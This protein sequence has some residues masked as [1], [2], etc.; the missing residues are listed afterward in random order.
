MVKLFK[1]KQLKQV[2]WKGLEVEAYLHTGGREGAETAIY[3]NVMCIPKK[4][5]KYYV[6]YIA[7]GIADCDRNK[8]VLLID[9]YKKRSNAIAMAKI[10]I[11]D[12]KKCLQEVA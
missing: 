8:K 11:K 6:S 1:L 3:P 2:L 7:Y 9:V 12:N 5:N 10:N 4:Y